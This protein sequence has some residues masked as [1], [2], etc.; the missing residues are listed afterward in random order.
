MDSTPFFSFLG[1]YRRGLWR[2]STNRG[3]G[4]GLQ[5]SWQRVFESTLAFAR[6]M[7]AP[8][9]LA[10]ALDTMPTAPVTHET[11]ERDVVLSLPLCR[12]LIEPAPVYSK[13]GVF[14][15]P[16]L[17]LAMMLD[18]SACFFDPEDVAVLSSNIVQVARGSYPGLVWAG[19]SQ[20]LPHHW[21][22][23]RKGE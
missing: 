16:G 21:R 19:R 15:L 18:E 20:G 11:N 2:F 12:R 10:L 14:S 23:S 7:T 4:W 8:P 5:A 6:Y 3:L 1:E 17:L 9:L 22:S 13:I